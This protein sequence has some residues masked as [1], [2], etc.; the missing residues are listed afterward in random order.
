[1]CHIVNELLS[2]EK[3]RRHIGQKAREKAQRDFDKNDIVDKYLEL[4]HKLLEE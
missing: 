4:Y 1:M 3:K 2:N